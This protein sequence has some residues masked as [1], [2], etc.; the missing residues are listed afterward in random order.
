M[1]IK[2]LNEIA[3]EVCRFLPC[4][5]D[6]ICSEFNHSAITFQIL[7]RICN[8]IGREILI[9]IVEIVMTVSERQ[10]FAGHRIDP[11]YTADYCNSVFNRVEVVILAT[12]SEH[13][14][15]SRTCF[16]YEVDV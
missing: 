12:A 3:V 15:V 16:Y 1:S 10:F 13:M 9:K 7:V 11:T 5:E 8:A 14:V 2:F 6:K 4:L